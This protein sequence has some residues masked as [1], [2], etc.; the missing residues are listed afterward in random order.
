MKTSNM[1]SDMTTRKSN[2]YLKLIDENPTLTSNLLKDLGCILIDSMLY[3]I[4]LQTGVVLIEVLFS[5]RFPSG[6]VLMFYLR[7]YSKMVSQPTEMFHSEMLTEL[8][9]PSTSEPEGW[10]LKLQKINNNNYRK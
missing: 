2:S 4:C 6:C 7:S 5:W 8:T 3:V 10:L 1:I 9:M